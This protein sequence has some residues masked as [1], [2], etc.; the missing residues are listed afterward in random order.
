[1]REE[2]EIASM[3]NFLLD[4]FLVVGYK[5]QEPRVYYPYFTA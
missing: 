3:V 5:S 2:S 1:M 4:G